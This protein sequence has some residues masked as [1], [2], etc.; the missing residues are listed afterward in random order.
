MRCEMLSNTP[1]GGGGGG[2]RTHT[3]EGLAEIDG[4]AWRDRI[5]R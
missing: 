2:A 1:P 5:V 4:S 3:A